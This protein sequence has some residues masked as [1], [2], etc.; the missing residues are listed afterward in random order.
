MRLTQAI[1]VLDEVEG[2]NYSWLK[3]WGLSTIREAIRTA[4]SRVSATDAQRQLAE[5]VSM[6]LTDWRR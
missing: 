2:K 5:N 3:A 6:K 4:L 1:A